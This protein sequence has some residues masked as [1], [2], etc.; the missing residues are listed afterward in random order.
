LSGKNLA[1]SRGIESKGREEIYRLIEFAIS[2]DLT[3]VSCGTVVAKF[4]GKVSNTSTCCTTQISSSAG[5][6]RGNTSG[7]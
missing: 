3:F 5:E 4:S 7:D 6:V 1:N 2:S